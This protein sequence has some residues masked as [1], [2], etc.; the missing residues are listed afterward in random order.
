[1]CPF[2]EVISVVF[3]WFLANVRTS[4]EIKLSDFKHQLFELIAPMKWGTYS[5][6]PQDY[7]FRQLNNF[8]EIEVIFNDDVGYN[9]FIKKPIIYLLFPATPVEIRAPRH[10][11]NAFSLPT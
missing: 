1:M 8:G 3:P 4:L 9:N 6:K 11:P 2:G 10:F 7:V 5:V